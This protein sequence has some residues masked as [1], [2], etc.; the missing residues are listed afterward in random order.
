MRNEEC[1]MRNEILNSY[2]LILNSYC[3]AAELFYF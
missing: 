3:A 1:V 2:F